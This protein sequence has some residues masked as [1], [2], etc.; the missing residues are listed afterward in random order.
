M[1]EKFTGKGTYVFPNGTYEGDF[2]N[3]VCQGHGTMKFNNY[4]IYEGEWVDGHMEG[5]GT[6]KFFDGK[7]RYNAEYEGSFKDS[8]FNGL[9]KMTYANNQ[10]FY[11]NWDNG[12]RN[13]YGQLGFPDGRFISGTWH[14]D[15]LTEGLCLE[16]DCSRYAGHF[17]DGAFSGKGIYIDTEGNISQ[18][19]WVDGELN[20]G[21]IF[22]SNGEMITIENKEVVANQIWKRE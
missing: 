13:G 5:N 12:N 15:I 8:K 7:R 3:G 9:G 1:A 11:G 22:R 4:D 2:V 6:Y 18:G 21:Y 17:A 10:V 16:T 19:E 14:D 20:N